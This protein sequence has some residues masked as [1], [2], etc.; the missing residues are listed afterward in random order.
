MKFVTPL[1]DDAEGL[2][3]RPGGHGN[4]AGLSGAGARLSR[5]YF[6][7]SQIQQPSPAN[8]NGIRHPKYQD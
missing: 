5:K 1:I 7:F 2:M 6:L 3:K 8:R 4:E